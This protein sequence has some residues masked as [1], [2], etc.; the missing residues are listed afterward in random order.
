MFI[1][2]LISL[3]T[4]GNFTYYARVDVPSHLDNLLVFTLIERKELFLLGLYYFFVSNPC[5]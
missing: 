5:V 4:A 2:M 1:R 3:V